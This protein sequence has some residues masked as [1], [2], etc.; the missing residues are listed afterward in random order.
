MSLKDVSGGPCKNFANRDQTTAKLLD[1]ILTAATILAL[2][3]CILFQF[4][5]DLKQLVS[6]YPKRMW[7]I[8]FEKSVKNLTMTEYGTCG[9]IH[10]GVSLNND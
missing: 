9:N 4:V 10:L 5:G 7:R 3:T 1:S 2:I 6:S 8:S